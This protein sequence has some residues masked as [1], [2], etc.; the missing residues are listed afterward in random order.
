MR[1]YTIHLTL[2]I[3]A[4][5]VLVSALIIASSFKVPVANAG[6]QPYGPSVISATSTAL[7]SVTTATQLVATTTSTSTPQ[8]S[9]TRYYTS[10]CNVSTTTNPVAIYMSNDVG[11]DGSL[12]RVT[13]WI[14]PAA[15]YSA[16]YEV[17]DRLLYVGGI[18]ASSTNGV[19]TPVSVVDYVY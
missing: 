10:I 16:C 17:T 12:G 8:N 13:A 19:A 15:G 3:L 11:A 1:T 6:S 2:L 9:Y 7:K 18:R 4:C 5:S 14:S